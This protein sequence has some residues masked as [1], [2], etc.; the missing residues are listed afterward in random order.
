MSDVFTKR[1]RS[2]VMS[3]IRSKGNRD[4]ELLMVTILRQSHISGWRRNSSIFGKPDFIFP[5]KKIAVFVDGCFWHGCSMHSNTPKNNRKFWKKK[6]DAN[7]GRDKIV[8]K[9]LKKIGWHV[10]RVWEHELSNKERVA[11]RIKKMINQI[12]QAW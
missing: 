5:K 4:T 6:L 12:T 7:K 1:K 9:T 10:L 3:R 11:L 8:N 2:E